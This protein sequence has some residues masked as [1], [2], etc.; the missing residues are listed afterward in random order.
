VLKFQNGD[1]ESSDLVYEKYDGKLY[2]FN[3]KY[4][5]STCETEQLVQSGF[6]KVRENHK[7]LRKEASFKTYLY[8]IAYNEICNRCTASFFVVLVLTLFSIQVCH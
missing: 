2:G 7:T 1:V 3:L 5:K 4:L 6:L 8:T